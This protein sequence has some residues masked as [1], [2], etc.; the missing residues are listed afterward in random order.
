[1]ASSHFVPNLTIGATVVKWL[2]KA[3]GEVVYLDCHLMVSE[4]R[5][6]IKDFADAGASGYTIHIEALS[7]GEVEETLREI[8]TAGM[9]PG[10]AIKPK[11]SIDQIKSLVEQHLVDLVCVMT[12]EPGFGGQS[13]MEDMMEKVRVRWEFPI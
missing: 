7:E 4:P 8:R 1:M 12:V 11:T 5:K 3:V 9:V 10:I 6:W 13:F 2:R